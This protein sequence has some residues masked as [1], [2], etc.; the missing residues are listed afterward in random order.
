MR[1][2]EYEA[3][4][5]LTE[6]V[7]LL[8][9]GKPARALAGGTDLIDHVRTGRLAPDLVVDVKRLPELNVLENGP[10]GLRLGAAV[11]CYR[12]YGDESIRESFAALAESAHIIGGWQ[13]Q[14]RASVG[15]N[16]CTS[17]PAA[18]SIPSLIALRAIVVIAGP[19]G[20]R[21]VPIEEFCTGPGKNIL[22]PGELVVEFRLP[23]PPAHSGSH[24]RRFIP[25]NEMD[26]AVVG[27]GAAVTLDEARSTIVFSPDRHWR[28][29]ADSAVCGGG[30]RAARAG[31]SADPQ[32][33]QDAAG[34]C[35]TSFRR[36]R[37]CG[38]LRSSADMLRECL[39]S[40]F[41][42]KPRTAPVSIENDQP[43]HH[44]TTSLRNI[45]GL[46]S[47]KDWNVLAVIFERADLYTV[48][49]QRAKGG[50]ADKAR[51]G[52]KGHKR[53][54]FWAVFDQSGHFSRGGRGVAR[55]MFRLKSSKS[56]NA[57]CR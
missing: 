53:A 20:M 21:E 9:S 23:S 1:D 7:A 8:G 14:S 12:I 47:R 50:D 57:S 2:F 6:A 28:R 33:F 32:A 31:R 45:M 36:S 48:A 10:E 41:S 54:V 55:S 24:Y 19:V 5:S 17:G 35:R 11:P 51:D 38:G 39:W 3:P 22:Q 13:I 15:G 18:D 27:V 26:I 30:Q 40:G 43:I 37:T 25:R 44:E 46:F 42:R 34:R 4:S 29:G 52:V 56:W 49:G 16:V